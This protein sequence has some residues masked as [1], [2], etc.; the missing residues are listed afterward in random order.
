M[1]E[2]ML[3]MSSSQSSSPRSMSRS[4][5]ATGWN[6]ELKLLRILQASIE[7]DEENHLSRAQSEVSLDA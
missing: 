2:K 6:P 1:D 7:D 4:M 5:N 3:G